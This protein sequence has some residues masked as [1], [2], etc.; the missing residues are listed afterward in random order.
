MK[1]KEEEKKSNEKLITYR[2]SEGMQFANSIELA[3]KACADKEVNKDLLWLMG[4]QLGQLRA[5]VR[6]YQDAMSSSRIR[7]MNSAMRNKGYDE[8][9][10]LDAIGMIDAANS[11][12]HEVRV[13]IPSKELFDDG[14]PSAFIKVLSFMEI[15]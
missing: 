15:E 11:K 8:S 4:W 2:G 13:R 7:E 12:E 5:L 10:F 6:E 3:V 14:S 1:K 9:K